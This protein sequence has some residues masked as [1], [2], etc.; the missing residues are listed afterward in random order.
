MTQNISGSNFSLSFVLWNQ[1][2]IVIVIV[3]LI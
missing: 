3:I 2:A 1:L